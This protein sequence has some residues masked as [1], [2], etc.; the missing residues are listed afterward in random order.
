MILIRGLGKPYIAR[1]L[2][3]DCKSAAIPEDDY[4]AVWFALAD[5]IL[6]KINSAQPEVLLN[7]FLLIQTT[8]TLPPP[9]KTQRMTSTRLRLCCCTRIVATPQGVI[10]AEFGKFSRYQTGNKLWQPAPEFK[11]KLSCVGTSRAAQVGLYRRAELCV[12]RLVI[13]EAA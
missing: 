6:E 3:R 9:R 10:V 13:E 1:N 4:A 11:E 2:F 8:A 7:I 12:T 5:Y